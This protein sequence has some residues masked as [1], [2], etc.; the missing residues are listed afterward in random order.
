MFF[1]SR[2][3]VITAL[4]AVALALYVLDLVRRRKLSEE[5]SLLWLVCSVVI[6][7]LGF[8]TPLLRGITHGLGILYESSTV[9]AFGLAF[10]VAM[11][12]YLSVRLSRLVQ[13][14]VVLARELALLKL[15]L[16]L[17]GRRSGGAP[18]AT[19]PRAGGPTGIAG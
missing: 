9:F 19:A 5:F 2:T 14:H 6:A 18:A 10:A 16:E 12:L 17:G 7:L 15:D 13:E 1:L 3:Q 8:S 4:G 11:L